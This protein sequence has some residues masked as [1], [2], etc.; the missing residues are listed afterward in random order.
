MPRIPYPPLILTDR[1]LQQLAYALRD[2]LDS[3][4]TYFAKGSARVFNT[5]AMKVR[6]AAIGR[7]QEKSILIEL[8][9]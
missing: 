4:H 6:E 2:R 9:Y 3:P 1:E 7:K 5:L 8:D